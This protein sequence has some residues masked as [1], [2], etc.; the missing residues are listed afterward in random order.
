M[1][2]SS[3]KL[4]GND[5]SPG[6]CDT[7]PHSSEEERLRRTELGF[8]PL[9]TIA[10]SK[11]SSPS[12]PIKCGL[13]KRCSCCLS[14]NGHMRAVLNAGFCVSELRR[15]A[16]MLSIK[17]IKDPGRVVRHKLFFLML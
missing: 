6:F 5:L 16:S 11:F 4:Y 2:S 14:P 17:N 9:V 3:L 7:D 12:F 13:L 10:T 1:S 15:I 8:I